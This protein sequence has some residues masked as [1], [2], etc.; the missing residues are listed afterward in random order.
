MKTRRRK[1]RQY[2]VPQRTRMVHMGFQVNG[3]KYLQ[4]LSEKSGRLFCGKMNQLLK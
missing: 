4:S 2:R 3:N 1:R